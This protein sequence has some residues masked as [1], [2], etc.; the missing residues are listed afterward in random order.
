M[1]SALGKHKRLLVWGVVPLIAILEIVAQVSVERGVPTSDEWERAAGMVADE[2]GPHD[3][4]VF[5]PKWA[6]FARMHFKS[7]I[8]ERDFGRFDV[9]L[10]DNLFVVSIDGAEAEESRGMTPMYEREVGNLRVSKF[11]LPKRAR[12]QYDFKAHIDDADFSQKTPLQKGLVV[13][14]GFEPRH[15]IKVPLRPRRSSIA[16]SDVPLTGVL[17]G[18]GVIGVKDYR[19]SNY[20]SD[21]P[22]ILSVYVNDKKRG[23]ITLKNFDL[24][25]R[26][27]IPLSGTGT[28]TVRFEVRAGSAVNR[29]F[30]FTAD[31]RTPGKGAP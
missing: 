22:V 27:E 28:G 18:Y 10:Y 20:D 16:F 5:A 4:V 11:A 3:V 25:A 7:M 29:M 13:D 14:H 2:K 21:D 9:S 24:P 30:G 8:T 23:E 31:V 15:V 12:I 17:Y 26:F 6:R 1:W 19:A